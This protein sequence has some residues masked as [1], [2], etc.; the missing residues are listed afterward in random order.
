MLTEYEGHSIRGQGPITVVSRGVALHVCVAT[1][2]PV[3]H[4]RVDVCALPCALVV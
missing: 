2:Q 3:I 4:A 1:S